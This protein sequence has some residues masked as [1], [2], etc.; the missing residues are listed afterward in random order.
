MKIDVE[1]LAVLTV[2]PGD[3]VV[4]NVDDSVSDSSASTIK[5]Y[6]QTYFPKNQILIFGKQIRMSIV[7]PS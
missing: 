7:R 2:Q 5:E 6:I 3:V 4:I 1:G